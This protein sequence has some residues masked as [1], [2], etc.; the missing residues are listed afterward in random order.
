MESLDLEK[1]KF[2][3]GQVVNF[4]STDKINFLK[5]STKLQQKIKHN[6]E[7]FWNKNHA[8]LLGELLYKV[9]LPNET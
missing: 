7:L 3:A 2:I 5:N 6:Q 4:C 1:I 8:E 9:S